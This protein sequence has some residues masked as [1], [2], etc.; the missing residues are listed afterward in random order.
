MHSNF[1]LD[2]TDIKKNIENVVNFLKKTNLDAFY[3]SSTDRFLNEY[4]PLENCHRYYVTGFTGSTAQVLLTAKGKVHLFVDGRYHEQVD[5]EIDP[6]IVIAEKCPMTISITAALL[7]K[8]KELN[9]K[10]IAVEGERT[11]KSLE[12]DISKIATLC[13]Y[14]NEELSNIISFVKPSAPSMI[15]AVPLNITGQIVKEKL[16]KI[17]ASQEAMLVTALDSLAWL[18]NAR[19]FHLPHQSTFM[20]VGL[21]LNDTLHIFVDPATTI[22]EELKKNAALTFHF[23]TVSQ[24]KEAMLKVKSESSINKV[25]FNPAQLSGAQYRLLV[26]VFG[27]KM[28]CERRY[29]ITEMHAIKN[30]SEILHMKDCFMKASKVVFDSI[31][32]TKKELRSG[33][34]VSE[35]DLYNKTNELYLSSGAIDQ[36]FNTIAAA[37]ANSS[38]IHYSASDDKNVINDSELILLDCGGLYE[39]GYSTD[40]TR[41]FLGKGVALPKQKEIYTLVL[42][43]LLNAQNAIVPE[44]AQGIGVDMLARQPIL[45]CGYD[46]GHGTGHGIGINVHEGCAGFSQRSIFG[47]RPGMTITIEPGL[48]LSGFGGVRLENVVYVKKHPSFEGMVCFEPMVFIGF[49]WELIDFS[50]L[51]EEEKQWF[52]EYEKACLE[53]GTSFH[54]S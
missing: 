10:R 33:R 51:N 36:S 45:R 7:D 48:Y 6:Q 15:R 16:E 50:M 41:S 19:G 9:I 26:D 53:R 23:V 12:E 17:L 2:V 28:L 39:G 47:I 38:I 31:T 42:K 44:G 25:Y 54:K 3:I 13:P 5:H 43:G 1:N 32:W 11:S 40:K 8:M 18:S 29:G 27:E 49:D 46:Y 35:L 20:G 30:E 24:I 14:D 37:G 21:A 22:T 52:D 34:R 4:V